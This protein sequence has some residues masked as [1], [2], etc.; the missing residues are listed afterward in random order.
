M[1]KANDIKIFLPH[2]IQVQFG[3]GMYRLRGINQE[4]A[5]FRR[6]FM[7]SVPIKHVVPLVRPLSYLIK[8]II[9]NGK[10]F[11]PFNVLTI[12]NKIGY[13]FDLDKRTLE[14]IIAEGKL[15]MGKMPHWFVEMCASWHFDVTHLLDKKLANRLMWNG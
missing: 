4:Q 13:H 1:L 5:I 6:W 2:N 15:D 3:G 10:K 12:Y 11:I 7:P 14:E 9:H 8:P